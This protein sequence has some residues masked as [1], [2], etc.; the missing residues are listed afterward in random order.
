MQYLKE[1]MRLKDV[2]DVRFIAGKLCM[3][4][5]WRLYVSSSHY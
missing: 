4:L 3:G 1:L 2:R 5:P